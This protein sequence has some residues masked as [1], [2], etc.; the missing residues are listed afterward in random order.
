MAQGLRLLRAGLG[1]DQVGHGLGLG[2]IHAAVLEGATGELAR[3]GRADIE[4]DQG[5]T[6]GLDHSPAAMQMQLGA[7]FAGIG[8]GA[9]ETQDQGLIHHLAVVAKRPQGR[10][11]RG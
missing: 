2:Q 1:V 10:Q 7:V 4:G 9:G 5:A 6:G 3:F 8:V 11:T